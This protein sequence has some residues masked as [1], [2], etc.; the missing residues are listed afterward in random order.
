MYI[1]VGHSKWVV[2]MHVGQVSQH[3]GTRATSSRRRVTTPQAACSGWQ[4][5]RDVRH[6]SVCVSGA[7]PL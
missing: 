7:M 5:I 3:V 1:H 6:I 2:Y 4:Y